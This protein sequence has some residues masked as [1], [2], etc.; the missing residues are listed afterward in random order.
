MYDIIGRIAIDHTFDSLGKPH[1]PGGE[2]F[3]KYEKMQQ[4]VYGSQGLRQE[5]SVIIPGL[6]KI[7]VGR[8]IYLHSMIQLFRR[9]RNFADSCPIRA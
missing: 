1:G 7:S 2:L 4:R 9:R 5:L 6:D 8:Q 3:E